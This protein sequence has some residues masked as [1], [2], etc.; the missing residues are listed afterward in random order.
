MAEG[1]E[2]EIGKMEKILKN[3]RYFDQDSKMENFIARL[4]ARM[5]FYDIKKEKNKK[6]LLENLIAG[7]PTG[8][9]TELKENQDKDYEATKKL[10]IMVH[11][12]TSEKTLH[13]LM[14][15]MSRL[16]MKNHD[17]LAHYFREFCGISVKMGTQMS[18]RMAIQLFINGL[19]DRLQDFCL[20]A[21]CKT[22]TEAYTEAAKLSLG[23]NGGYDENEDDDQIWSTKGN[24]SENFGTVKCSFCDG[25]GHVQDECESYFNA[26][27][28]A[29]HETAN[30]QW[31]SYKNGDENPKGYE[32]D[33]QEFY[34]GN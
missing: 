27:E 30:I 31:M 3:I 21:D 13:M 9:I 25:E 32:N 26:Q 19:P 14:K 18:E 5:K 29:K 4:E 34:G 6:I 8:K 10:L 28:A 33:E 22:M 11:D 20:A 16:K 23:E 17:N 15:E 7:T 2:D 12:G 1:K 24:A